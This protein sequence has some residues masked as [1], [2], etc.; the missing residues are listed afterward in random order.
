VSSSDETVVHVDLG[1]RSYEIP[2]VSH[3]LAECADWLQRWWVERDGMSS[4]TCKQRPP[5][6]S[7]WLAEKTRPPQQVA[8]VVTDSNVAGS[9]AATVRKSL[10]AGG[11]KCETEILPAGETSKSLDVLTKVYDRLIGMQADRRTV[12]VAVG[13]GVVGD[14]AGFIAATYTRGLPFVQ[15]PTTLLAAVDSSVGGKTGVNHPLA[16][17]MIGAFYQPIGVL[18]DTAALATLPDREYRAGLAE[19]VKYGVILDADF[20]AYLEQRV[21]A[22]NARQADAVRHIVAQSCR[23]KADVVERDGFEV[24]GVRAVLNYGHTFG[25]AFEALS[26]YGQL[27]HGEAVAIGMVC[28]SRLAERRGLI[29]AS[30]T[31]RQIAL[32]K[33]MHLPTALPDSIRLSTEEV[34]KRMQLDKKAVSGSLRFVLPTRLGEVKTFGDVPVEDVRAVLDETTSR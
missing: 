22:I 26:G 21:D 18:I 2:I 24:S 3:K 19:V 29:D 13:G 4:M 20:F 30:L 17:N 25:H 14:A 1:P 32:L 31:A 23:L 7:R 15:I 5:A 34:L 16:K 10:E 9:H 27:L 11:W 28:A 33:A 12:I 6:G 8:L